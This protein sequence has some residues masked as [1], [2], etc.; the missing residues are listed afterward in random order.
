MAVVLLVA[1]SE[2][3]EETYSDYAGDGKIRYVAKCT[4]FHATPGWERLKLEWVNGT[5]ATVDKIKVVWS[6]ED[7]RDSVLLPNT[8]TFYELKNLSNGTYRFDICAVDAAGNASLKETTYGRPYTKEHEIMLAFTRGVIKPYFLKNKLI[9]FSD[10]WNEN[11][12]E[13]KLQYKD[14]Q[15]NTQYY[16]FDKETSYSAFVTIDDVSMN[17][18]DTVYVLRKGR[19]EDCPDLIEFDPLALNRTK[20]FSSGFVNAI[21]R[22]YGYSTKTQEKE[23][24]FLAFIEEVEELEFD[25]DIETFED[26]LYCPNL[27]KLIFGKNRYQDVKFRYSTD[28]DHGKLRTSEE[29][30]KLVLD[31]ANEK[32]VLGLTIDVYTVWNYPYFE[33][34]LPY[35][36]ERGDPELPVMEIIEP[37]A[38][39]TYSDG[40]KILCSPTDAYAALENLLD[41]DYQTAWET[42]PTSIPR[43][44]NMQMELLEETEISGIKITQKLYYPMGDRRT[45]YFMPSLITIQVSIDGAV[46]ENVTYFDSNELGCGSGETTLLQFPERFRRVKYIKFTLRDGSDPVGNSM[47]NLGDIVLYKLK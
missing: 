34:G 21:E 19:L 39:K 6:C 41:D 43:T 3:L 13:I 37:D 7:L 28:M 18:A 14:T 2:S 12:E 16:T 32:D 5:D 9:F 15:G 22:R 30:S 4:D 47:I 45:P 29:R 35:M 38:L 33:N 8:A 46:W 17:P 44:Y 27:K 25:Y 10:Q 11:I 23:I 42:T 40:N 20:N 31:K 36:E 26:V 1:C 24:E